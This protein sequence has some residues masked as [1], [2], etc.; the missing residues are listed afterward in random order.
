MGPGGWALE[1][2]GE[3]QRGIEFGGL[4]AIGCEKT[5]L[6]EEALECVRKPNN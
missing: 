3:G 5:P 6:A 1:V 2:P 4:W